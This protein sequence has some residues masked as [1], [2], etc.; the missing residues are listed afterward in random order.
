MI[1]ISNALLAAL[2][3]LQTQQS[4]HVI[5]MPASAAQRLNLSEWCAKNGLAY[6]I[7]GK[8]LTLRLLADGVDFVP[9]DPTIPPVGTPLNKLHPGNK[10]RLMMGQPLLLEG[11]P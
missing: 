6:W 9:P 7:N 1:T 4:G 11:K 2:A 8:T 3:F 5:H 10:I